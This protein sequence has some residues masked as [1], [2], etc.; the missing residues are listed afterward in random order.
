MKTTGND[1][2]DATFRLNAYMSTCGSYTEIPVTTRHP[3]PQPIQI[4]LAQRL[5]K[6]GGPYRPSTAADD[7]IIQR[8]EIA[9]EYKREAVEL[10]NK[11]GNP[12]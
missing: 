4:R 7:R 1:G 9:V 8:E 6:R 5:A 3:S 11:P 2:C 10:R 12:F